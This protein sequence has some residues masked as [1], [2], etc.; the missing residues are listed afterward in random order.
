MFKLW[1]LTRLMFDSSGSVVVAAAVVV[2]VTVVVVV[3]EAGV[4]FSSFNS[5]LAL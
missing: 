4:A 1:L 5:F 3:V 2:V